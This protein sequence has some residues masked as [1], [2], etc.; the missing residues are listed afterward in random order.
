MHS[1]VVRGRTLITIL[2]TIITLIVVIMTIW[3]TLQFAERM[4]KPGTGQPPAHSQSAP[5]AEK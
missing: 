2:A 3:F 4:A 5:V 1:T